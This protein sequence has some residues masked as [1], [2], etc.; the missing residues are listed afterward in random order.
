MKK[1]LYYCWLMGVLSDIAHPCFLLLACFTLGTLLI[2]S[3]ASWFFS[4]LS[5]CVLL[6]SA[7][8][9]LTGKKQT[10]KLVFTALHHSWVTCCLRQVSLRVMSTCHLFHLHI[11]PYSHSSDHQGDRVSS[12]C[13]FPSHLSLAL[14]ASPLN[15][16][17]YFFFFPHSL[18]S[19]V[20]SLF[21]CTT[22]TGSLFKGPSESCSRKSYHSSSVLQQFNPTCK[23]SPPPPP[24][25]LC[26][27]VS[28]GA[29][30]YSLI[31]QVYSKLTRRS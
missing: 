28:L 16:V 22:A 3:S 11:S 30:K 7:R 8:R 27:G 5:P 4:F 26:A 10:S 20:D 31:W 15:P 19:T 1:C 14:L 23:P 6:C 21:N 18:T 12:S 13:I 24:P 29:S 25:S 2:N 9:L 17:I